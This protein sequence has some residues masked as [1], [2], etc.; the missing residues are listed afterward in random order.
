MAGGGLAIWQHTA[1]TDRFQD[2]LTLGARADLSFINHHQSHTDW[3]P[4]TSAHCNQEPRLLSHMPSHETHQW[5]TKTPSKPVY[6]AP[7]IGLLGNVSE[8][9]LLTVGC[10]GR[11][12]IRQGN[13]E[14]KIT[15]W[16]TKTVECCGTKPVMLCGIN[17]S[18]WCAPNKSEM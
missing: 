18:P 15:V 17:N 12:L 9:R 2:D 13:D 14:K 6:L 10:V 11:R 5:R 1:S 16:G 8:G 3:L 7:W 4:E